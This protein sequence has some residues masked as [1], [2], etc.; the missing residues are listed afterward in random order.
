MTSTSLTL[1]SSRGE[2]APTRNKLL[3]TPH[4]ALTHALKA[5]VLQSDWTA[6]ALANATAT[7]QV[8]SMG[9]DAES[10]QELLELQQAALQRLWTLQAGWARDWKSWIQYAEQVK[11]AN[12]M[13]KLAER[14]GNI[15]AQFTQLLS[16]QATDLVG[17]QENVHVDYSYWITEKLNEKRKSLAPSVA[18]E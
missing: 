4:P 16:N 9:I 13:S 1:V 2:A 5:S 10:W 14:E 17:L 6:R 3:P 12:T 8:F 7:A 18:A 11:G 15:V